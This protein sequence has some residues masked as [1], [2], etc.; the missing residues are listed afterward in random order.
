MAT[1][2]LFDL[3]VLPVV[4][5]QNP[6]KQ[7]VFACSSMLDVWQSSGYASAIPIRLI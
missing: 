7:T 2:F 4:C 6:V 1:T 5:I 3:K